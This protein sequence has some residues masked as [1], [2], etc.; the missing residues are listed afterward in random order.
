MLKLLIVDGQGG[1]VGRMLTE[2]VCQSGLPVAITAVGTNTV[3]TSAML[4]A[5]ARQGATGE[6]AV[7][8]CAARA[9]VIM[10]PVGIVIADALLGEIT[11]AMAQAVGQSRAQKLLLPINH[12][13]NFIVGVEN[14]NLSH[15]ISAAVEALCGLTACAE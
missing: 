4:R 5:G 11:P 6:N 12:C 14:L 15:L 13:D 3:A 1:G 10:G 8:V 9:D 2:A 7:R